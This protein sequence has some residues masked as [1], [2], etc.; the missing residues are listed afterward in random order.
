[1]RREAAPLVGAALLAAVAFA[2]L[3]APRA[4]LHPPATPFDRTRDPGAGP[5]LVL[6]TQAAALIPRGASVAVRA[7]SG[8]DTE[9][10]YCGQIAAGLLP[11][12]RILP[13]GADSV[14]RYLVVAGENPPEQ[15]RGRL[16]L[17]T[18]QGAVWELLP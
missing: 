16:L 15:D 11:G 8:S 3:P 9:S 12:R 17:T 14:A 18:P 5:T 4:L 7:A 2:R 13:T 6:M 1:M 10:A